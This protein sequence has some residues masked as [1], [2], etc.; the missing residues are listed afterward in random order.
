MNRDQLMRPIGIHSRKA[1]ITTMLS[2]THTQTYKIIRTQTV[3]QMIM[4]DC[5]GKWIVVDRDR[6]PRSLLCVRKYINI[7]V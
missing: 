3:S 6:A 2:S 5:F 7:Y 1:D 4:D